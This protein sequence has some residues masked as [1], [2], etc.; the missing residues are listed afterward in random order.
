M[1]GLL[2]SDNNP[3][4]FEKNIACLEQAAPDLARKLRHDA[5]STDCE[6]VHTKTGYPSLRAGRISLHSFYNPMKEACEWAGHYQEEI[7][8]AQ[9]IAVLGFGL[10]YHVMQLLS[11]V[12]CP[13]TVFEPRADVLQ[14]AFSALDL[15]SVLKKIT[16]VGDGEVPD[17][18]LR[19]TILEHPPSVRLSADYFEKI[20][21]R[22]N[23]ARMA[24]EGIRILVV[25]PVYGGSLPVAQ[26]C[27]AAMLKMGHQ[28]ELVDNSRFQDA[29]FLARDAATDRQRYRT[30]VDN[31]SSFISEMV[32][33]RCEKF[34]PDIVIAL[35]QAPLSEPCVKTLRSRG[36]TTAYWFVEDFRFMDYWRS[37]AVWYDYFFV[38]QKDKFFDELRSAGAESVHYLPMAACPD[39]HKPVD[40]TGEEQAY[41]GSDLSFVGAGYY[42]RR[43][44][45]TGLLDFELKVWG[46]DWDMSSPLGRCVQRGGQ[47][48]EIEEIVRIFN[49][50]KININLHSSHYHRGINPFGDFVNPRTFEIL[51]CGGFQLLDR[52]TELDGLFDEGSEVIVFEDLND[53]RDKSR[54]YLNDDNE[55]QQI[56]RR[57]RERVLHDHTYERRLADMLMVIA[58]KGIPR[59]CWADGGEP[60][61]KLVKEA[62]RDTDLGQFLERFS[63]RRRI[64]LSD[65]AADI[66]T[67]VGD[68][69]RT[70]KIFLAM[71]E[72]L[73]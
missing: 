50:S 8:R 70:E 65:V 67:G 23:S 13:V 26:Y 19:L 20:K 9:H 15:T 27:S 2:Y 51:S 62:G 72:L 1:T 73:H 45:L 59:A 14:K 28:V 38:I 35:A 42:N 47:R 18:N 52:R 32:L 16:L 6:L 21:G 39:I 55:R 71:N 25:S 68:I 66:K 44:F 5:G 34:K 48:L 64:T 17:Y 54:R 40:L 43:H 58:K 24:F 60:V 29:L 7:S 36:V 10:G 49:A 56:A 57:G 11:Q 12:D 61:G 4:L 63:G 30:M 53:L 3:M 46:T 41:Y 69:S 22:L 31:L 37:I 33:S